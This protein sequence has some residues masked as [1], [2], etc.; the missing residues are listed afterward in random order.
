MGVLES[1]PWRVSR[2]SGFSSPG[3][4]AGSDLRPA[5]R[6]ASDGA[7]VTICGRTE[8]RLVEAVTEISAAAPTVKVQH[9]VVDVTDEDDVRSAVAAATAVTGRLDVLFVCAGGSL[10]LGPLVASDLEPVAATIDLNLIGTFLC[11]KHGGR[12]MACQGG[13]SFIGMSSHAGLD[14]FRSLGVYG[15]AKAGLD[16][17][18]RVAADELGAS[19]VRVNTVRPGV[20]ATDLMAPITEGGAL[21]DDYLANIPLGRVGQPDEI[22]DL[23]RFLAGPESAWITG[24]CISIDGGQSVRRGA[25]FGIVAKDLYGDDA[26]RG[27]VDD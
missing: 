26:L 21:L 6:L 15:A 7:D 12:V 11:I 3:V 25:D 17:L 18:C 27:L 8:S 14:T 20:V 5:R 16:H 4:G 23:V 19:G 13:G 24:Q 10:H 22:A 9:I 1:G 2:G